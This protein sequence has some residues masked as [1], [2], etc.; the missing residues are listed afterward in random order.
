[1]FHQ[2]L[3]IPGQLLMRYMMGGDNVGVA[4]C[5]KTTYNYDSVYV[6]IVKGPNR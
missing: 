2:K 5:Y 6:K 1:M 3:S 4:Q